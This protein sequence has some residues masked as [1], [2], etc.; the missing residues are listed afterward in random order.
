MARYLDEQGLA[1]LWDRIR[2]YVYEC[3]CGNSGSSSDADC[4]L[5]HWFDGVADGSV[6]SNTSKEESAYPTDTAMGLGA[7]AEGV[8][9]VASGDSSHAEG[10]GT[11]A[12]GEASHTEGYSFSDEGTLYQVT[13]DK[14]GAHAEGGGTKATGIYAHAEGDRTEAGGIGSHSEGSLTHATGGDSHAEGAFSTASK[15]AAHAEG[16]S[17]SASGHYS[18]AEGNDTEASGDASHAEGSRTQATQQNAHAEGSSATAS[19]ENSH[20]EGSLT[21]ASGRN[22][23]AEGTSTA[24]GSQSHAEGG[25]TTASG[26][27]SHAAGLRTIA[28]HLAQYVFGAYNA[29]DPSTA[30]ETARGT[31]IEIV[32]NGTGVDARS[33][34]RTLD[35]SGNETLAGTL[36]QSSDKR[37]K[38]HVDYLGKDAEEFVRNLK[39]AHYIKD[40]AHHVGFYAQDVKEAD[41]WDCM[42]GEMNG[43]M[44]LGYTELIAPLVA[45][46][47]SLEKRIAEL[48]KK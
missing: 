38:E 13:A 12:S 36:T 8:D 32:G 4:C 20:A 34:A 3:C 11:I 30:S 24:S 23:H 39:P 16:L 35:W 14:R 26:N 18:H 1:T 7:V 6:R 48:E 10:Y 46:C 9:T 19:G 37:L 47:Q 17:T 40:D 28:K 42:T 43:Y 2:Q 5:E 27:N 44:T 21:T 31:Y 45:Y 15:Q 25:G 29:E 22:S 41:K 33:N